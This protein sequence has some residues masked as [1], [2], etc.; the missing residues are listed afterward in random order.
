MSKKLSDL[1]INIA[2]VN[3]NP[4]ITGLAYDSRKVKSGYLYFAWP[5]VHVHGNAFIGKA[6]D[7][8]AK[9]VIY[10]DEIPQEV[11]KKAD[12]AK[13]PLIK[14]EDSRLVMSQ[15]AAAFFDNP[16][17]KLTVIGVTG[18]EGKSTT[19]YLIWQLLRLC[20][21]KA[22][23]IS[24]VQYSLGSEAEANPEHQTTP[25]STV[26]QEKLAE[27]VKN[28]W[29]YAVVESSS[30]GLSSRTA[31]LNDVHFDVGVMMNVTSEHLEFHGTL[32]QYKSDK[33]N[34][35]RAMDKFP[36][37]KE[38]LGVKRAVY[39]FGV[40][41]A[42][43]KAAGYFA[44]ATKK[45]VFGFC[46][47]TGNGASTCSDAESKL[48]SIFTARNIKTD[49]EGEFFTIAGTEYRINLPGTFNVYNTTASLIVV[50]KLLGVEMSSLKA[51]AE[52]LLPVKGRMTVLKCGQ[53]FEVIVDYAH[54]PSSFMT[55]FPPL[56]KRLEAQ[57][58]KSGRPAGRLFALFG[59]GGER[60][61]KKRP[62][63]GRI[64][65]EY[66]D[67]VILTDEDPRG[68]EP[69]ALLEDIAAGCP[70]ADR[71]NAGGKALVRGENL[72]LIPDRPTAIRTAFE[73]AKPGDIV[74]L[75]GKAHENSI[76]YKDYVMPYDE[77][78]EAEKQLKN[79]K[80]NATA[81]SKAN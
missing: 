27:M 39:S 40:V 80:E 70:S 59:S 68:E 43:D 22:G 30:H 63:Q 60:D 45:D 15:V 25:E 64:A 62:E 19:V 35:F 41:N 81:S 66:C 32:E 58:E 1:L 51:A 67:Y 5:G 69:M 31:R 28:G 77:I 75:L 11:I 3:E 10:Q 74:L 36:H 23:F 21:K 47:D 29:E 44:D 72:L 24:T 9:A 13:V 79:V 12:E 61:T 6:L 42:S 7:A 17:D 49:S 53:P 38:I 20:G 48:T 78:T 37:E 34:L 4:E 76:I 50:S 26:V 46:M 71:S 56:R 55:I 16:S 33:A 18:T 8:G 57:A 54:T 65:A 14:V 73:L 52:K 2:S